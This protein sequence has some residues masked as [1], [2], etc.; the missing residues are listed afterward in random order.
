MSGSLRFRLSAMMFLQYAV[1]GIWA[2]ILGIHLGG[3]ESFSGS[4]TKI[5]LIYMTLPI[6]S[7]IAPFIGG[8]IA[9]RY[10]AAQRFLAVSQVIGGVLL[11]VVAQLTDF[12]AIFIG[13]LAYNLVYAPTIALSNSIVFQHWPNSEFSKIRMWGSIGW[14]AIGWVFGV[15]WM[16]Y[17]GA[18]FHTPAMVDCLY[19]AAAVSFVY[20][21][22][23]LVLP[24]TPP[25]KQAANPWAF[26]DAV[27]LMRNPAFAVM[28]AVSFV[29][30][31][32]LQIYFIWTQTFLKQGLELAESWVGPVLTFGQICEMVMMALLPMALRVLGFRATMALGVA[33]W[34]ARDFI[35]AI[36]QP[37]PLVIGAVTLHGVGFAFFFTVIFMYADVVAP[38]DIK[39][40][41]QSFLASV[42]IGCGMLVGSLVQGPVFNWVKGDWNR[43]YLV[44]AVLCVACLLALLIGFKPKAQEGATP[45]PT[46]A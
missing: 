29:V 4:Q 30:A 38:K 28:A 1:W 27:A 33:A 11:L 14:I 8:Q 45:S 37:T 13:M 7:I 9:D 24:H 5:G 21:A 18:L 3:L 12:T 42:S 6:A 31:I 39:S 2:P 23:A 40:S 41:A 10:F 35:F 25:S 44:P 34:A 20:G 36:G 22:F 15:L 32:E 19:L 43:A 17:V 26:L 46:G 16:K